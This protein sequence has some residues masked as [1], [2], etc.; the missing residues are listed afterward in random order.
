M[1]F[2][3]PAVT[4]ASTPSVP[5]TPVGNALRSW[6]SAYNSGDRARI[7][8]FDQIHAPWLTLD[9]MMQGRTRTGGYELSSVEGGGDFWIVFRA[10]EKKSSM[11]VIGSMVVRSYQ[12]G[13]VT[14]LSL[15]PADIY[16]NEMRV[17]DAERTRVIDA[18]AKLLDDYYLYPDMAKKMSAKIKLLQGHGEYQ[19]ITD[20]E[21]FAVRVGDDLVEVSGD[22]HIGVDFFAV[23][24]P[25]PS[26]LEI[27]NGWLPPTVDSRRLI[28]SFPIPDT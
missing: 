19:G 14:L 24:A 13:H 23:Q 7:E 9:E 1:L 28:I 26:R 10:R 17:N 4:L 3:L 22:K 21:I 15:V 16:R 8:S 27:H 5:N 11:E 12:P 25:G 20:G 6:L 2:L 18:A